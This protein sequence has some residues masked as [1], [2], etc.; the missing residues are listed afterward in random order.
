[1][2]NKITWSVSPQSQWKP[3]TVGSFVYGLESE[4]LTV[5]HAPRIGVRHETNNIPTVTEAILPEKHSTPDL[6]HKQSVRP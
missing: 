2:A 6:I 3:F 5:F 1:M 4:L